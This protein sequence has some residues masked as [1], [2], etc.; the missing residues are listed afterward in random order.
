MPVQKVEVQSKSAEWCN[1]QRTK[2]AQ[3]KSENGEIAQKSESILW[4]KK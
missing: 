3:E 2:S 4:K 1:T